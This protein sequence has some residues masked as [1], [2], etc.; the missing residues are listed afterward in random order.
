MR[1]LDITSETFQAED[2]Y[3][4]RIA[5]D[6]RGD[7]YREGVSLSLELGDG[8]YGGHMFLDMHEVVRLRDLL[9]S[10]APPR[11]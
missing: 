1:K 9:N 7:P 8:G 10:I 3:E 4:L 11:K 6:N 2:G 5:Y